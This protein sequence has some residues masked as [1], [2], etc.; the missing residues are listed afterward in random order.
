MD[1]RVLGPLEVLDGDS[2]VEL[3]GPRQRTLLAFLL[4]HANEAVAPERLIEELW[5]GSASGANA[6][7]VT[8]SR[9]RKALG[10]D[11]RLQ[12][13]PSGYLLRVARD[14]CDRDVF[15]RLL[16]EARA[17]LERGEPDE[18][19]RGLRRALTLWRGPPFAD[20]RYE[21]FAQAEIA[22][23]EELRLAC[24]ELRIDA[25]LARG[26]HS[27]V[28]GELEALTREHP[29]RQRIRAQLML[30]LYRSGRQADALEVYQAT[31]R[32]LVEELGIEPSGDLRDLHQAILRQDAD[33]DLPAPEP[34][35]APEPADEPRSA[36]PEA[37]PRES[38][39]EEEHEPVQP[40]PPSRKTVTVLVTGIAGHV[41]PE[42]RHRLGERLLEQVSPVL[43]R[44][45]AAVERLG[46]S[47]V[48]GV[49]GVPSAHEDDALR[50]VRAAVELRERFV[51]DGEPFCIGIGTGEMLTGD[52]G[53]GESL[54]T[55]DA[56]DFAVQLQQA[57]KPRS[58]NLGESTLRLVADAVTVEPVAPLPESVGAD[59]AWRL[60]ELVPGAPAIQRR[61]DAS[62]IGRE[63]ELEQLR[64][65]LARAT[66]ERRA[67]L[68]T[69]FGEAGIGKTRLVQELARSLHGEAR[70]LTGRCLSYGEGITYWPLR[71]IVGQAADAHSVR[72]LLDGSP[73][74][75]V[76]AA[77]LE[78]AIGAGTAGAVNEEV[79][80]AARKLAEALARELPLV[81]AFEDVHWAEPTL[82]DLVEHLAD[83]VRD[84]P[85]LIVCLARPELLDGRPAWAGGKLNAT[86]IL[87]EPLTDEESAELLEDIS[88]GVALAAEARTRITT[89][90]EGNP[91][92]LEQMLAMLADGK[93]APDVS[94][95]PAIQ[96][97][98]AARL[99]RLQPDERRVL[100]CASIAGEVF[101]VGG[102]AELAMGETR[103]EV[104]SKLMT[105]VRKELIRFE[106]PDWTG[107]EAFRF[108]HALI[109]D[110]AY[111]ELSK[112]TR[113]ELHA[114]YA[115]W[116]EQAAGERADEY[117]EFLG[118]HLEQAFRYRA[119][120]TG[121]DDEAFALADRARSFLASAGRRA[122]RRG[123]IPAMVNLLERARALPASDDRALLE[124][125][126]D[127]GFALFHSG[128]LER[129]EAVLSDAIERA[130]ALEERMLE[131]RAWV[132]W[133]QV[134]RFKHPELIEVAEAQRRA[135]ESLAAF[136]EAGDELALGRAWQVLWDLQQWR[137]AAAAQ[138][139]AAEQGREHARR[140]GSRLDEAGSLGRLGRP[141]L[142]GPMPANE[143]IHK[144]QALLD[145]LG[146]DPLGKAIVDG[147]L[148][149]LL[150]MQ[151]RFDDGRRL[152]AESSATM[153]ELGMNQL[154]TLIDVLNGRVEML[155]GAPAAAE[156]VTRTGAKRS[157]ETADTWF[158]ALSSVDLAR[159]VCDQDRPAESLQ[160]LDESELRPSPPDRE[161]FVERLTVRALALGRMGYL[162]E[163]E[164][165][166]I[167]AVRHV[168]G[169]EFLGYHAEALLAL[170]EAQRLGGQAEAA[171]SA[172]EEAASLFERK[173]NVVSAAKARAMLAELT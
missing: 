172:L 128:Q 58:V 166:A 160:I 96:A 170:A 47:R 99:D 83:W 148:A 18:A 139:H 132:V 17:T 156:K 37:Q 74:A 137:G 150:A 116:L 9:L 157:I 35:E 97:L 161:L 82:L 112:Q 106:P 66:R 15:E 168:E 173:G 77:R 63:A 23:L 154:R 8:V 102:V 65:I 69:I 171:A 73:D 165:A 152:V 111:E 105:L 34:H 121:V 85:V 146:G 24:L 115:A 84:A 131:R 125:A 167:A 93:T 143:G 1:F 13:H 120:L 118:Y 88:A 107:D 123:D 122:F 70:V 163:A 55:G 127:L 3:G 21:P 124:L 134:R 31:R 81:L 142:D 109:R 48:M 42:V 45:G 46:A 114:R 94:V 60:L 89:A 7:Q 5:R 153:R 110:A 64:Q 41:D 20:V 36:K 86:S 4:V 19:A 75:E 92:F 61:F 44:H 25:D 26:R 138:E 59:A 135:E 80:W 147:Y 158:Y 141:V 32:H 68:A 12:R 40:A 159:A 90:A 140:A 76:V 11:D 149:P 43:E 155:A 78:S 62:F 30:A 52:P 87:L 28:A 33:L 108:R 151:G 103:D 56:G 54:V 57:G 101:H 91:L 16:D 113:S 38:P 53:A 29:L 162:A 117:E 22:R 51:S 71:E 129:A 144:L 72:E 130:N 136:Q 98:L 49:F 6:V 145:E 169:T 79:F 95:P 50:A 67:H 10:D 14:E 119:E 39:L 104:S 27:E 126:P 100:A 133:D 164:T 2:R